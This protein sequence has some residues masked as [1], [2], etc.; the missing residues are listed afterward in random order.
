[1]KKLFLL[2]VC[3]MLGNVQAAFSQASLADGDKIDLVINVNGYEE[4][5]T[6]IQDGINEKQWYYVP[7]KP[8]LVTV[9]SS[10]YPKGMPSFS[11]VK[12]QAKDPEN[13]EKLIEGGVMQACINLAL[14]DGG[15]N[16]LKEGIAKLKNKQNIKLRA[17]EILL[18]PLS[19][20][21]A[22]IAVYTPGG[23]LMGDAPIG[24]DIGP[25]FANQ[26]IPIQI[27]LTR[28]G[29]DFSDALVKTGGGIL[30]TY[31][32]DYKGLTPKC[33]FKV[34]VDWKQTF[35]HFSTNTKAKADYN[36]L[37][38]S[39]SSK[40][41]IETV[42]ESLINSKSIKVE[43][44]AGESFKSEDIDKYLMP[45]L[46][47]INKE[48]FNVE[49]PEKVDPAKAA[50]PSVPSKRWGFSGGI[51]FSLK[52]VEKIKEGHTTYSMDRQFIVSR[53]TVAG[54]LIGIGDYPKE[55]QDQLITVMPAGNWASAWYSLPDVGS[56]EDIGVTEVSLT[57]NVV[58]AKG[59][60]I[61]KVPQQNAKWTTKTGAWMDPKNNERTSLMFP[62]ASVYE[63]YKGKENELFYKQNISVT[64]KGSNATKKLT[65]E[66]TLPMFDGEAAVSTPMSN[67]ECVEVNGSLLTWFNDE[68]PRG[69]PSAFE[70]K[71]SDLTNVNVTLESSKPRN[72]VGGTLSK[73]TTALH[74]L[75]TTDESGEAPLTSG[76]FVFNSK[77]NKE[78]LTPK[79][80]L[81]EMGS[82]IYLTDLDYLPTK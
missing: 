70:G 17:D 44:I 23:S 82:E 67:I 48:I 33:G 58:D 12:Y 50:D 79:N 34:T 8:R 80:V 10:K 77:S 55:I 39:G 69:V 56:A 78:S 16:K 49:P 25:N 26:A 68:Y 36:S 15:L 73:K 46:E 66:N 5:V 20:S 2:V 71:I 41:S 53:Q 28:L 81:E 18:A 30:T 65:F 74:L 75:L 4:N 59:K 42:R 11:L 61:P 40:V 27:N 14:P 21:N 13:P 29:G 52:S 76:K 54:G 32:F 35:K 7:N 47:S 37:F 38:W 31:V 62:L 72:K 60:L 63:N 64:Q 43:S 57:I 51:N 45:I 6:C 19:M 3:L 22:K 9:K 24:P 1:M